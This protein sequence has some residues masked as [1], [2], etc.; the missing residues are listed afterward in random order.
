MA[1]EEVRKL[2]LPYDHTQLPALLA[3][4]KNETEL[5]TFILEYAEAKGTSLTENQVNTLIANY[6]TENNIGS[7]NSQ[8]GTGLTPEQAQKLAMILT[9]GDGT[10]YLGDDGA[11]HNIPS[12]SGSTGTS[13]DDTATSQSTTWSSSKISSEISSAI[14]T[15]L[16]GDY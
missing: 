3:S 14:G 8:S 2:V 16:G 6:I 1:E 7:G 9:S 10:K 13:I 4:I 5:R 12:G 15:A 11:Y